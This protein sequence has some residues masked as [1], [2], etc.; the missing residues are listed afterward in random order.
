MDTSSSSTTLSTADIVGIVIGGVLGLA[1]VIGLIFSIY[2]MCCK[3]N[4]DSQ[5]WTQPAPHNQPPN[6][7]YG[8][9]MNTGYYQQQQQQQMYNKPPMNYEQ[10][11]AYSVVYSGDNRYVKH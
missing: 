1:T 2:T 11:P 8:R 4:N 7:P 10:P 6:D 9:S 3:K 5:V